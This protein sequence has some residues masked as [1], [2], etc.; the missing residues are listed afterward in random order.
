VTDL[1]TPVPDD[2]RHEWDDL[3]E[4]ATAAQFAYHVRDSP[5]ISDAAYH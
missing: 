1:P 2:A 5:T 3:A 4:Q